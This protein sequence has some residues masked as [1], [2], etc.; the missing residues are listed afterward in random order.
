MSSRLNHFMCHH[1]QGLHLVFSIPL[2]IK[3]EDEHLT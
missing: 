3:T 1:P 2:A